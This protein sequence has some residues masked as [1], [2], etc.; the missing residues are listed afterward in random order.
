MPTS[1]FDIRK[2]EDCE[3]LTVHW[4]GGRRVYKGT[5]RESQDEYDPD[6]VVLVE[7]E[8]GEDVTD[9]ACIE[10][11]EKELIEGKGIDIE[12]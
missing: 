9:W 5:Y 2:G 1:Y 3:T 7:N 4:A 10:Y 12:D 6:H 11:G 8:S